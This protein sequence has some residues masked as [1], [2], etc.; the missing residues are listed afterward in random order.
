MVF[1]LSKLKERFDEIYFVKIVQDKFEITKWKN[2]I[3]FRN[4][5]KIDMDLP[6]GNE[7]SE[8][9]RFLIENIKTN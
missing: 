2:E 9:I 3:T 5:L 1:E 7:Y 8:M 4:E 6:M